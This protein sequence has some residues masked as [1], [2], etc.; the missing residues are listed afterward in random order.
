MP[1]RLRRPLAGVRSPSSADLRAGLVKGLVSVPDGLATG[2]L[3]GL[4]PVAGL[5]GYLFG[6]LAGA[7]ST[8]SV[9]MSVQGT[10][11]MAVIVADTPGLR[12]P[13]GP[14]ALATLV[15][16]TGLFMLAAGLA[17]LGSLVRYVPNAVLTGF[18]NAVALNIML[19]QLAGVTGYD[20]RGNNR[21]IRA[22]DTL[23]NVGSFQWA[24]V[25]VAA[26]TIALI[27][28]LERTALGPLGMVVAVVAVSGAAALLPGLGVP[29]LASV[30]EVP[31]SLPPPVLPL[32]S[33]VPD[34]LI[35]AASLAFV[36][37]VQGAAIAQSQ[38]N[39]DG[40]YPDASGDFRGQGIANIVAG[41]LRGMPVGGSMSGTAIVVAAGGRGRAANLVAA[42]VMILV[43]LLAG[44]IAGYIALPT[45][46]ALL[47]LIGYRT[48]KLDQALM[49][50]RTGKTQA[51]IMTI[52]FVLT[53]LVPM[54]YAVLSGVGIS[55]ILFVARQSNRVT[56]VRWVLE[57]H[58]MP[59]EVEP[60]RELAGGDVV[61]LTPYGSLFF[62]SAGVFESQLPEV[63]PGSAGA[64][65]VLRLR[66]K[67]ELGSTFI[68]TIVRYHER[69]AAAGSWLVLSGVGER[70][71]RQLASTGALDVLGA[72]NVYAAT[73]RIGES[74]QAA[75]LRAE[76]LQGRATAD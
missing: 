29:D 24:I 14:R 1:P 55:V 16:L 17:R 72:D 65:V 10:S 56:V 68:R 47:M 46:A 35:P 32:L 27:L 12:G 52:T 31:Q 67:E 70:V 58:G 6:A 60:P 44:P 4:N 74:L 7:V 64:V 25:A 38:P 54:Q 5:Y 49:V 36:R 50:W 48:F 28:L 62:A 71:R 51:T 73:P 40:R 63:V 22:V 18:V 41:I 66:G 53:L 69:L 76:V 39:P 42:G 9:I 2:L 26:L 11:A 43:V 13:D 23:V 33:T 30:A 37:L 3:A 45:L 8:S 75:L 15:V 61:V 57:P 19:A 59:H 34:L 21:V 20:G